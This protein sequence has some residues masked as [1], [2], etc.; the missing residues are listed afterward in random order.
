MGTTL[1]ATNTLRYDNL[2]LYQSP[3]WSGFQF[4]VG[5]S[6]NADDTR[7]PRARRRASPPA[8]TTAR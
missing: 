1:S 6:F 3:D 8:T 4:G 2:V 5:Y 7:R